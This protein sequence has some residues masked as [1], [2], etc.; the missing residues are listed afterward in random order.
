MSDLTFIAID[1]FY[2]KSNICNLIDWMNIIVI[3]III[4]LF[5][6]LFFNLN[7]FSNFSYPLVFY[8]MLLS[9][10]IKTADTKSTPC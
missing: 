4:N 2:Y 3:I 5:T 10:N 9:I 1:Q 7:F 6:L 8:E